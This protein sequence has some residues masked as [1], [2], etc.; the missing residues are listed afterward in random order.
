MQYKGSIK[1]LNLKEAL[2]IFRRNYFALFHCL[3]D[4]ISLCD[5]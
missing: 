2:L 4:Q 3:E 1:A 5:K